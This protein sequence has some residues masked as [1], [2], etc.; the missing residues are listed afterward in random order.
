M[1]ST[2]HHQEDKIWFTVTHTVCEK[3]KTIT[4]TVDLNQEKIRELNKMIKEIK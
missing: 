3:P 4:I 1:T 2:I